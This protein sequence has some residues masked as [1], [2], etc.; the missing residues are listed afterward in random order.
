MK[1]SLIHKKEEGLEKEGSKS[2]FGVWIY[3][4]SDCLLFA[5]LFATFVI[6]RHATSGGPSG[7]EIFDLPFVLVET[8]VL[9]ASSFTLGIATLYAHHEGSKKKV[10]G[11]ISLT[12]ILGI[13]F[14]L[15]EVY[16]FMKLIGEGYGPDRSAFLSAFF[17]LL[18][19]HGLHVLFG[20][21]WMVVL[22]VQIV[23][24]GL[25]HRVIDRLSSLSLFWHFIDIIWIFIF[26]IVYL[27]SFV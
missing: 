7:A 11:F 2:I 6:L 20:L 24:R 22:F 16:E 21:L 1:E 10:L 9:L 14:L 13:F 23:K 26:T 8:V 15:M 19:V 5:S 18:G 25:E 3:L 27:M 12:F 4:M 17:T